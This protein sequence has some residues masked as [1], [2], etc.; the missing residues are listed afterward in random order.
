MAENY[1]IC[2][3][4]REPKRLGRIYRLMKGRG[5][6]IQYSVFFSKISWTELNELKQEIKRIIDEG[7]DDVR[8]YPLPS[9]PIVSVMGLGS[10]IPDGVDI[11]L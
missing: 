1:L 4:I 10:R 5:L 6:H 9:K 8:I 2:Y 3:D 11:F 7:E